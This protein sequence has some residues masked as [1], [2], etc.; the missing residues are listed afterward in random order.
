MKQQHKWEAIWTGEYPC[1]CHGEWQLFKDGEPVDIESAGCP[2]VHDHH[3]NT[4]GEYP[5]WSF[6]DDWDEEWFAIKVGLGRKRW[7]KANS[8]W[9]KNL[10]APFDWAAIYK[11]FRAEDWRHGCCGGCI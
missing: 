11:A 8:E 1:F 6:N 5:Q 7:C 10:D 9:L 3:A 4:F 2:F